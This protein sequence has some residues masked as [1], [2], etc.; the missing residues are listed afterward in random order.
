MT[1]IKPYPDI[2]FYVLENMFSD[3]WRKYSNTHLTDSSLNAK[4]ATF[5]Y[6]QTERIGSSREKAQNCISLPSWVTRG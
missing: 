2:Q 6:T 4:A 1:D 5:F 3:F